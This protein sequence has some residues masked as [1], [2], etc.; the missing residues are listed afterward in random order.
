MESDT[1]AYSGLER[2]RKPRIAIP[3]RARV[4][5]VDAYG[6]QFEDETV[7]DNLSANGL[8]F[9]LQ[10]RL[11]EKQKINLIIRLATPDKPTAP[12][13]EVQGEVLR[14]EPQPNGVYGVAVGFKSFQFI[15]SFNFTKSVT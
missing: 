12:V 15:D 3:F 7:T 10:R 11:N 1:R 6:E 14:L 4:H 2:R 13:V 9:K 8:F 5:G